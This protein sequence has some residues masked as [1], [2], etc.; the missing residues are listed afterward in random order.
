VQE[1]GDGA[2]LACCLSSLAF[3]NKLGGGGR[4][5]EQGLF[6]QKGRWCEKRGRE[7]AATGLV[8]VRG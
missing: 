3:S 1:E 6:I 4:G 8:G 2:L 5:G 7:R